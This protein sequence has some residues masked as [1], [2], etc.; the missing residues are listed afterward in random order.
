MAKSA[1]IYEQVGKT[2][3]TTISAENGDSETTTWRGSAEEISGKAA[4]L[5]S[6]AEADWKSDSTAP[7]YNY[8][9]SI[10][11][12]PGGICTLTQ[13][14]TRTE[15]SGTSTE[16]EAKHLKTTWELTTTQ[17][18]YPLEAFCGPSGVSAQPGE[19]RRWKQEPNDALYQ[20]F[21]YTSYNGEVKELSENSKK[22][23]Q[24][25][26]NGIESVMRFYPTLQKRTNYGNG[27]IS[28]VAAGLAVV[29]TP[30]SPWDSAAREW[31]KIGDHVSIAE[32][33]VRTRIE[34]WMG[35]DKFDE[36]LYGTKDRWAF[37]G[38]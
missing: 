19:I 37:G 5:I 2:T 3:V 30:G 7:S 16:Q 18:T 8:N 22:I 29:S 23:A 15:R 20:Q 4:E 26:F 31:L 36:N 1:F 38:I 33:G 6:A 34:Q 12:E 25:I 9:I 14:K 27:T 28:G 10:T 21:K 17:I 32:D 13:T 11:T 35:A 24:K